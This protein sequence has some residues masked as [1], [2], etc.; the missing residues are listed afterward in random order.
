MAEQIEMLF[1]MWS[2]VGQRNRQAPGSRTERITFEEDIFSHAM[3][4]PR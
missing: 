3:D 1:Q 4:G 2:W